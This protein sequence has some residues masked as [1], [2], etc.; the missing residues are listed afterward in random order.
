[1]QELLTPPDQNTPSGAWSQRFANG[2]QVLTATGF[3]SWGAGFIEAV[4]GSSPITVRQTAHGYITGN[5]V[6]IASGSGG[7]VW[8][9]TVT[10]VDNYQLTSQ[11]SNTGGYTPGVSDA[12][13]IDLQTTQCNFNPATFTPYVTACYKQTAGILTNAGLTPWLQLGEVGWWFFGRV[14]GL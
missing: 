10:D 11:I 9:I 2:Q 12:T 5:T 8:E 4:T 6:H 7:G 14:N 13:L 1:S 3:G